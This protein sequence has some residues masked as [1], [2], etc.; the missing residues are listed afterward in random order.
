MD[1]IILL[2]A[3][4]FLFNYV[5]EWGHFIAARLT[6][7]RVGTFFLGFGPRIG[8]RTGRDGAKYRFGI[9]PGASVQFAPKAFGSAPPLRRIMV[10]AAGPLANF[11]LTFLL[12]AAAY[13]L[14]PTTPAPAVIEVVDEQGPAAASGL[15]SGDRIVAVDGV[16]T[17]HWQD[18]GR[19]LLDRVGDSG[20]LRIAVS[21]S[22]ESM[23]HAIPIQ[24]WQSGRARI[25][26]FDGLGIRRAALPALEEADSSR[27]VP[28]SVAAALADTVRMGMSSAAAGFKMVFGSMSVLN[29][30]GGLQATQLGVEAGN[31]TLGDYLLILGLFSMCFGIIN[32]L[33]GPIV[34]GL[35]VIRG[36]VEW[37]AQK[38]LSETA[39]KVLLV[40][41]TIVAFGPIP[42]CIVHELI[43]LT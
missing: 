29:F 30:G 38:P 7:V 14:Y 21:R 12:F 26:V 20:V 27:G 22:G 2:I 33:P 5:H 34:D 32:S 36:A 39:G 17:G 1:L 43:R 11:A 3:G 13:V 18:V 40:A 16:N 25:D 28:A 24:R 37:I 15:Q 19:A 4:I 10:A 35:D 6:G 23:D 42:I 8:E 31:L 41:G 9:I